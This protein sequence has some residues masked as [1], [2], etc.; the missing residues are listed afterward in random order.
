MIAALK[1]KHFNPE[2]LLACRQI[3]DYDCV[4]HRWNYQI[5]EKQLQSLFT[6]SAGQAWRADLKEGDHVDAL[7]H[8]WDRTGRSRGA[9]WSQAKITK[10]DGDS[11]SLQYLMEPA[12][13]DRVLD[14]WS[15][16]L[17]AFESET[18]AIWEW[19][20]TLKADEPVDAQ[21]DTHKWLAA[22][23][24]Q[25]YEATEGDRVFPMA[26]IGLRVYTPT[27]ARNDE[28]G[29]YDGFGDR[30]DERIPLYSPKICKFRT[31]SIKRG[32]DDDEELD[33][34]LDDYTEP[35]EGHDRAWGV[36]RPR[37]CTSSEY[38]R[39]LNVFCHRGG[40]DL[41]L[42]I[43]EKEEPS[44]EA[45]GFNLW[46]LAIL[47]SLASLPAQVYHK[48]VIAEYA[49]RLRECGRNRLLQ[50]PDRALRDVRR[51][52]IEGIVKA[53]DALGR[54]LADKAE[55][56]KQTEV[57]KL[58]V[59]LLCLKSS[60]MERR[61]QGIRDLNGVI[62]AH[63]R[64]S[65][66]VAGKY[67]VDWMLEKG[68]FGILFDPKKT[69]LQ[70]VQRCEEVLRLLLQEDA[71][72]PELLRDFWSL[73]KTELRTEAYK[74]IQAC[75]ASLRQQ[76]LDFIFEQMSEHTARDKLD[77]EEFN[78]LSELG[79][80]SKQD[81]SNFQERVAQFFWD[82]VLDPETQNLELI[83][84]CTQKYRDMVRYWSIEK[85]Q[86]LLQRL[87]KAVLA[88][89]TPTLPG[90]KLLKGLIKDQDD[91]S[92]YGNYSQGNSYSGVGT[93]PSTGGSTTGALRS[94]NG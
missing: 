4:L 7:L 6:K 92:P 56:E 16:E 33:E 71:L 3:F 46:V 73:T 69:H 60:Y 9:G 57:L 31:M 44:D 29:A 75:S 43:L 11:L 51:E 41:V 38:L 18:K 20:E 89:E 55:R 58:E 36:P 64:Y 65:S 85:K 47:L 74:I 82:I 28:K 12:S 80:Y 13:S 91:R 78:C 25:I 37:K 5:P 10:V 1:R 52:A 40:L 81:G 87:V 19:K 90:L 42:S 88:P 50:A 24:M 79:K 35:A 77:M 68:V 48:D 26:V 83:S 62:G 86:G 61:I 49:P 32:L 59:A 70:L 27:G 54:R 76:H 34:T 22:T 66:K 93:Y 2:F 53:V 14:R 63:R 15:I 67:L 84:S 30:F 94:R 45:N 72:T 23:I 8:N 17:A 21:D 39:L